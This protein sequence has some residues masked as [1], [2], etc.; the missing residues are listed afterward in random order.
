MRRGACEC[1]RAYMRKVVLRALSANREYRNEN[2][3]VSFANEFGFE[4][5]LEQYVC[6]C[7]RGCVYVCVSKCVSKCVF[8]YIKLVLS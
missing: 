4:I 5:I 1:V 8:V 2:C 6:A 3:E 7:V